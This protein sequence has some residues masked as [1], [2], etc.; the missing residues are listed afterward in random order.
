[1]FKLKAKLQ[2]KSHLKKKPLLLSHQSSTL[3]QL[4][5]QSL[6]SSFNQSLRLLSLK[7]LKQSLLLNNKNQKSNNKKM[8]RLQ[9]NKLKSK[10]QQLK[11]LNKFQ[12][13][14][15]KKFP[16][17]SQLKKAANHKSLKKVNNN[18]VRICKRCVVSSDF[19]FILACPKLSALRKVFTKV[20]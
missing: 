6:R 9:S 1:M 14:F 13:K 11:F 3:S 2:S 7:L 8:L 17:K 20:T 10:N 12:K 15:P 5:N 18:D 19:N 4:L 16:K